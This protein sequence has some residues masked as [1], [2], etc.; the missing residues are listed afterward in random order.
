MGAAG[1][2]AASAHR[3]KAGVVG[4][5]IVED[6]LPRLRVADV[7]ALLMPLL[8][9]LVDVTAS[10]VDLR[11]NVPAP[12]VQERVGV[13]GCTHARRCRSVE[14]MRPPPSPTSTTSR[15]TAQGLQVTGSHTQQQQWLPTLYATQHVHPQ[16][17][18]HVA[19][20]TPVKP[21]HSC[22]LHKGT[23]SGVVWCSCSALPLRGLASPQRHVHVDWLARRVHAVDGLQAARHHAVHACMLWASNAST[24]MNTS[25]AGLSAMRTGAGGGH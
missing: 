4:L 24:Q 9:V 18:V 12:R 8:K 6:E 15:S 21:G 2:A 10:G 16:A 14:G 11:A 7:D 19:E 3:P 5:C 23:G 1:P 13:G 20:P 22:L 17:K 25:P